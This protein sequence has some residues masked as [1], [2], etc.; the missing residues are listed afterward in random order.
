M[1]KFALRM[2]L[3]FI[4]AATF[5]ANFFT[6]VPTNPNYEA[7]WWKVGISAVAFIALC[8]WAYEAASRRER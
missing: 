8:A 2:A 4:A 7:A 1:G 6:L 3:A 5:Y